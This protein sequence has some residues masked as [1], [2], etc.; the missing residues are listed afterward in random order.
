MIGYMVIGSI[1]VLFK[2]GVHKILAKFSQNIAE[3][4]SAIFCENFVPPPTK[5]ET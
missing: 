5:K 1:A 3:K 4:L 2:F